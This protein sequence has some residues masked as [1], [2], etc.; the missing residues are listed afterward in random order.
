MVD[1][2]DATSI[3]GD[4]LNEKEEFEHNVHDL[5]VSSEE[6]LDINIYFEDDDEEN[7]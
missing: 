2:L 4:E 6:E 5:D 1:D 7:R 3:D